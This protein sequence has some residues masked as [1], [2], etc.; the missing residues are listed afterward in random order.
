MSDHENIHQSKSNEWYTPA[1]YI[2]AARRVMG[3]IDLDPASST[4]ANHIVRAKM[5][6]A[7]EDNGL[8]QNWKGRVWLNPPYGKTNNKSNQGIWLRKL[9]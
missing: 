4:F 7:I 8:E 9:I 6:Y 3:E 2:E 1:P 5:Y